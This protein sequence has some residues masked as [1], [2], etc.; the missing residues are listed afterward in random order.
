MCATPDGPDATK[1]RDT[2]RE[3]ATLLAQLELDEL[4]ERHYALTSASLE[5]RSHG[6]LGCLPLA[7]LTP[8][9]SNHRLLDC[10]I[11]GPVVTTSAR[12]PRLE[13]R[14]RGGH[15]GAAFAVVQ[16]IGHGVVFVEDIIASHL[17][18]RVGRPV[19]ALR[20]PSRV[21]SRE[22]IIRRSASLAGPF[23]VL[24]ARFGDDR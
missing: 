20:S 17:C 19:R 21:S 12:H 8:E 14:I 18:A 7:H 11:F 22:N 3:R 2:T 15:G 5:A 23:V 6:L 4:R 13:A 24:G 9:P 10:C 16:R 1:P